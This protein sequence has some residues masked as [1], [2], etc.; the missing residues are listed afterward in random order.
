M[1][2]IYVHFPYGVIGAL[3][4]VPVIEQFFLVEYIIAKLRASALATK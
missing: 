4:E 1:R 2:S 3:S